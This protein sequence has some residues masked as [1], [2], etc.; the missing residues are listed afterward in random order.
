MKRLLTALAIALVYAALIAELA[1][2]LLGD[3]T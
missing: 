1:Y 3:P 2:L